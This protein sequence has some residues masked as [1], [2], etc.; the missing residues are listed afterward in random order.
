MTVRV[1]IVEEIYKAE[2]AVEQRH[3]PHLGASQIGKECERSV[4]LSF[5]WAKS[6]SFNGRMLRLFQRGQDEEERLVSALEKAGY[7]VWE[8]DPDTGEQFRAKILPHFSGSLDGIA[9]KD[10]IRYLLE[11]KTHSDKSFKKL[12]KQGVRE[13]KPEHFTQMQSYMGAYGLKKALYVAVNKNDDELYIEEVDFN[14]DVYHGIKD[15]AERLLHGWSVPG[16]NYSLEARMSP[17]KFC[18]YQGICH[19]GENCERNCRTCKHSRC[20]KDGTWSCAHKAETISEEQQ[21][22]GCEDYELF[23]I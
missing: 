12:L 22:I 20:E 1:D 11:F 18:D 5:R 7:K 17:C 8:N 6:P 16:V 14:E 21:R 2:E 3:R 13:A 10:G 23:N 4:W 9:E 19:L 15:K